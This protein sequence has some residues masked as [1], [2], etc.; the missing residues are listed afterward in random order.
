MATMLSALLLLGV[1]GACVVLGFLSEENIESMRDAV[2][3]AKRWIRIRLDSLG[4]RPDLDAGSDVE[5]GMGVS[6]EIWPMDGQHLLP[7]P[8]ARPSLGGPV[9]RSVYRGQ[10]GGVAPTLAITSLQSVQSDY[11]SLND[12]ILQS[13][14]R[15][16][17][18]LPRPIA[19]QTA[20]AT[21]ATAS[22]SVPKPIKKRGTSFDADRSAG[23]SFR[24][25]G[26][27]LEHGSGSV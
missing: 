1:V 12:S 13:Q 6:E 16:D 11:A 20:R 27:E 9:R 4:Q 3:E 25:R 7:L 8:A 19:L 5:A 26:A 15:R 23:V 24:V 18:Y 2:I 10:A 21:S 17:I 14:P 22:A